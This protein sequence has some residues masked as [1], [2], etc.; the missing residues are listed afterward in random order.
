M[1]SNFNYNTINEAAIFVY[2]IADVRC[3]STV[4]PE[5]VKKPK[6]AHAD[7]PQIDIKK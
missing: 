2:F 3:F 6:L 7:R 1:N 4:H 5:W